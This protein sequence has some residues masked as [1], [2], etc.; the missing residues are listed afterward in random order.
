[1][2]ELQ[3][4]IGSLGFD[5]GRVDGIFGPRTADAL[6]EFQQNM[7]LTPDGRCGRETV[8]ELRR[9]RSPESSTVAGLREREA[10]RHRPETLLGAR[11]A[12]A[13]FGGLG[14]LVESIRR[15]LLSA[16]AV[17][18]TLQN[19][20]GS[21]LAAQANILQTR[22]FLV[23]TAD[24]TLHGCTTSYY[25]SYRWE[26]PV[27]RRFAEELAERL[28]GVLGVPGLG[29][30]GMSLPVLRE[31]RMPAVLCEVGPTAALVH[32]G[33]AVATAVADTLARWLPG[34]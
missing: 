29:A 16:G 8:A 13:H 20:D 25:A 11:V 3:A 17:A 15:S 24:S 10:L 34:S 22:A 1:M 18:L 9:L 7:G 31:T 4:R 19:P 30:R 33:N 2:A 23:F 14:A 26:S 5:A 32:H 28:P 6:A 21:R 27:G 12:L